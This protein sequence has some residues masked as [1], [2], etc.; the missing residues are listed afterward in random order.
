MCNTRTVLNVST[1]SG[2]A[3]STCV[4]ISHQNY[5]GKSIPWIVL[6]LGGLLLLS[7]VPRRDYGW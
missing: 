2:I 6:I 4:A 3:A 5:H 7:T 1:F